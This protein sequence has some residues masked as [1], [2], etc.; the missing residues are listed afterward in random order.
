[1]CSNRSFV[2]ML[3]QGSSRQPE[4]KQIKSRDGGTAI[5]THYKAKA[6]C[7]IKYSGTAQ[8]KEHFPIIP[9]TSGVC[10]SNLGLS[11]SFKSTKKERKN[12][13]NGYS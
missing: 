11:C 8:R 6:C 2:E 3:T 10:T 1:M 13:E 12:L 5:S 4:G 9:M 7:M